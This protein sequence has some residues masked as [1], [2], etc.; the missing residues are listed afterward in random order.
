MPVNG[1]V[2]WFAASAAWAPSTAEC[3]AEDAE[4]AG[5]AAGFDAEAPATPP[6]AGGV[7]VEA[8]GVDAVVVVTCVSVGA[9]AC[10]AASAAGWLTGVTAGGVAVVGVVSVGVVT[11]GV[12]SVVGV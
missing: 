9:E 1:R 6:A 7:A 11:V 10:G 3:G 2:C 5:L 4:D 8:G 12:V